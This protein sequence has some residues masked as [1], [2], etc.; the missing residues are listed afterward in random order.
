MG[1]IN[2]ALEKEIIM[3]KALSI[4]NQLRPVTIGFDNMF[5]HFE[6][7]FDGNYF[8]DTT[9]PPYNIVKK[10]DE[11]YDIEIALAGYG[12]KDIAVDYAQ[13]V[14]TIK[15]VKK[16]ERNA[17]GNYYETENVIHKGIAQRYFSKSF[18]INDDVEVKGAELKDGLLKVS[19]EKILPEGKKPR[20]IEIK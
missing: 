12:K 9:Y 14:L 19:L 13:N 20:T 1:P 10:T 5:D 11:L 18:T 7:M 3:N 17:T 8:N 2:L 15:S 16:T 6:R 4:L